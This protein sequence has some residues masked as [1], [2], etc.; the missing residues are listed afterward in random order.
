MTG[1]HTTH[2]T[3]ETVFQ[4]EGGS[5]ETKREEIQ[6]ERRVSDEDRTV[7]EVY[8]TFKIRKKGLPPSI[9]YEVKKD[10]DLLQW[11]LNRALA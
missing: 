9:I 6:D 5:E 4:V 7:E 2:Y 3:N 11:C 10:D 8:F 1:A